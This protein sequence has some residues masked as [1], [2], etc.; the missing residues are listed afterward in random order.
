M[1]LIND[2]IRI[3]KAAERDARRREQLRIRAEKERQREIERQQKAQKTAV[4]EAERDHKRQV[5]A[6]KAGHIQQCKDEARRRTDE[7]QAQIAAMEGIL[8]ASLGRL[9]VPDLSA[10]KFAFPKAEPTP[11]RYKADPPEPEPLEL[12]TRPLE[13]PLPCEPSLDD[14]V[15]KKTLGLIKTTRRRAAAQAQFDEDHRSWERAGAHLRTQYSDAISRWEQE[16]TAVEQEQAL[17]RAEWV[18]AAAEVSKR[19]AELA[20]QHERAVEEWQ[21]EKKSFEEGIERLGDGY[22]RGEPD[23]V[24][25]YIEIALSQSSYPELFPE[26]IVAHYSSDNGEL[27]ID[28]TLPTPEALP[29]VKEVSYIQTRDEFVEKP[30]PKTNATQQYDSVIY[31]SALRSAFEA[32]SADTNGHVR[33]IVFNGWVETTNPAT[34]QAIRPCIA[35]FHASREE[36]EELDLGQVDPKACFKKLKGV[37]AS[38]LHQL[39][40]V[41][42]LV[43]FSKDDDRFVEGRDVSSDLD[44]MTNLA[45]MDWEDFEHLIRELFEG[46]FGKGG[47]EVKITRASRDRG[48]DAIAFDPDPI[49]GGKFVIQAKRYTRT[50][51]VDAVRDLY[52]TVINEGANKGILV[53]TAEYGPDAYDFVKDKPLTLVSGGELLFL[54]EKHGHKARIDLA[55]ARQLNAEQRS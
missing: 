26:E 43:Q 16:T 24:S 34:G 4:R 11:P 7:C 20:E 50:V 17:Q 14:P 33:G 55:E 54:L 41:Q 48:V 49:R 22:A 45:A 3:A 25:M 21:K 2:L 28:R 46:E 1:S 10:V 38:K 40:P 39:A 42:P 44:Q 31:Q 15:Y 30:I 9:C 47:A 13:D 35:S 12:P 29:K 53:T 52:G 18:K 37:A 19:N 8:A 36:F 5:A 32:F 6:E 27:L 51:G 23:A